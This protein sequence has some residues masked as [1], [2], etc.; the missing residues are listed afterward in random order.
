MVS[1]RWQCPNGELLTFIVGSRRGAT[2]I[3]MQS[4]I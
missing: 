2:L 1:A 3:G 4:G